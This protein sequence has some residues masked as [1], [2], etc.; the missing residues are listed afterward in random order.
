MSYA[1]IVEAAGGGQSPIGSTLY[2]ICSTAD[3]VASKAVT[4]AAFD[5]LVTGITI[6][7]KFTYGNSA[8]N[9]TLN[10]NNTG[11]KNIYRYGTTTP[12]AQEANSWKANSLFALTYDGTAWR[13]ND[14]GA[15]DAVQAEAQTQIASEANV[16]AQDDTKVAAQIAPEYSN[17]SAYAAGDLCTYSHELYVCTTAIQTAEAWTTEHWQKVTVTGEFSRWLHFADTVVPTTAFAADA[18]YMDFPYKATIPLA[19]VSAAMIADVM[20]GLADSLSGSYAPVA[21]AY[22]GGIYIWA[23][24]VPP[25]SVIIPTIICW[26]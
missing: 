5:A 11:A 3:N 20:F 6:H 15:I 4:M 23:D 13:I 17:S 12:G 7:V 26:R 19:G 22:D 14:T 16:R 24:S 25:A 21:E 8:L 2:G 18:T 9:P 10:V 1:G